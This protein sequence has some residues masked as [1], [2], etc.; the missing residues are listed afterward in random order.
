V[1]TFA[2]ELS[3]EQRTERI[4]GVVSFVGRDDSGSFGIL[5]GREPFATIL[6]W[7]LCSLQVQAERRYVALPRGV[8]YFAEDVLRICAHR[9]VLDDDPERIVERLAQEMRQEEATSRDLHALLRDLD[10]ELLRRLTAQRLPIGR[11]L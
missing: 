6:S 4:E 2:V 10:R 1:R 5:S 8:L 7:G 11:S 9:F 3:S